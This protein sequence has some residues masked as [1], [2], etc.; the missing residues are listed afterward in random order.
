MTYVL[1]AIAILVALIG[2]TASFG[3]QTLARLREFAVSRCLGFSRADVLRQL[4]AESLFVLCIAVLW[5]L[6][7]GIA[8]AAV[9]VFRVNPQSFH[10]TMEMRLPMLDLLS[11]GALLVVLGSLAAVLTAQ[12]VMKPRLQQSLKEDW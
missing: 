5:G 10:W 3:S 2:V 7:L 11:A 9:L 4:C 8:I 1:E 12:Q 6:A